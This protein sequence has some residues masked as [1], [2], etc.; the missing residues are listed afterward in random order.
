LTL[1]A[2]PKKVAALVVCLAILGF[3]LWRNSSDSGTPSSSSAPKPSAVATRQQQIAMTELPGGAVAHT[4]RKGN[5]TPKNEFVVRTIDPS[6]GD[7]DP[8]LRL[9]LLD[10][11]RGV[12]MAAVGRSLFE[13]N[14]APMVA[15][16]TGP[17]VIVPVRNV[18][19]R[20]PFGPEP[21]PKP[22]AD[23]PKP[24]PPPIPLKFYGFIRPVNKGDARRGFFLDGD[25][26][27]VAA[28]GETIKQRYK[29]VTVTETIAKMEDTG[30]KSQQ[31]LKLV[32]EAKGEN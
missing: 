17:K 16:M 4:R 26:I 9:E 14:G 18:S 1:G 32:P 25:V 21:P 20:K 3:M 27:L 22:L 7:V 10:R 12:K 11:L 13:A 28:E 19:D 30:S 5:Q 24:P 23:A 31:D 15:A 2:E 8:T 6:R 29:V